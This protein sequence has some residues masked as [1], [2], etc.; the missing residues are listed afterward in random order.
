MVDE[1]QQVAGGMSTQV[2][3]KTSSSDT[4][5]FKKSILNSDVI[6]NV[7][8]DLNVISSLSRIVFA[9]KSNQALP[10]LNVSASLPVFPS[11]TCANSGASAWKDDGVS[12][13]YARVGTNGMK[14]FNSN[15]MCA[16]DPNWNAGNNF[17]MNFRMNAGLNDIVVG[18]RDSKRTNNPNYSPPE[19]ESEE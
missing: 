5:L 4:C 2:L 19:E 8:S 14:P 16:F 13:L 6:T 9:S 11:N 12:S 15:G 3:A 1:A 17:G 10:P 7:N 18:T